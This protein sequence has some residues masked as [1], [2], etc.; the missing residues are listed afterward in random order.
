MDDRGK[1]R[2]AR[3]RLCHQFRAQ[4][5]GITSSSARRNLD[6][7]D[8]VHF[9]IHTQMLYAKRTPPV[10]GAQWTGIVTQIA[11]DMLESGKVVCGLLEKQ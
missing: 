11:V 7:A 10:A 9:G 8:D 5:G 3:M 6:S 4:T 1:F 2:K